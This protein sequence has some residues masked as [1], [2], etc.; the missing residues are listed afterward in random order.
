MKRLILSTVC[1]LFCATGLWALNSISGIYYYLNAGTQTASVAHSDSYSGSKTIPSTVTYGGITYSVTSIG[2]DAFS[3]CSRLT[4][5]TIPNSVTSIGSSAFENCT[6]LTSVTIPNSVTSIGSSAF[7]GCG[8]T[9]Y[10]AHI[11]AHLPENDFGTYSIPEGIETIVSGA[12]SN[13]TGLTSVTIPNSVTSIGSSAFEN[14]SGLKEVINKSDLNITQGSTAN[15]Y[16]AYYA[17]YV[18]NGGKTVIGDFIFSDRD[19]TLV[20]YTGNG[21]NI[22]LPENFNGGSYTIGASAFSGNT[23]LTSITIPNSVTSIGSSAFENC[24]GLTSIDV[25]EGNANYTSIDGVLY[26]KEK[27]TLIKCPQT[28][29]SIEIQ[30]SV[31]SIGSSA[32]YNCSG[33]TS[34][35]IPS[36]VT[37]IGSSAFY[38]CSGLTSVEIPS[39]VTGIEN[40]AFYNV[41][42]IVYTGSA[43]GSPWGAIAIN[44]FVDGEFVF[45]D[46]TKTRLTAYIGNGGDV[47]IPSS[48][49]TIGNSAFYNCSRLTSIEIPNSVTSI[50]EYAFYDCSELTSVTLPNSVTSIGSKAFYN[51]SGLKEV[52][53]KS[54]L[55]ITQGSTANGYVAYYAD[56]VCN[57]GKTVIGDFIFS[58]RDKTLVKY[59]GNGGNITLPENFNGGSYTIGAS[60]FSGNTTLTSI[61]IPNSV[62]SIGNYVFKNCSGL[63]SVTIPNSVTSI[64]GNAFERCIRLT[65]ITIPNSVTSIGNYAFKNCSGL[66]SVTIPN[67]VTSIG[68]SAFENC[69]GLTIIAIPSSVTSIGSSAFKGCARLK[70]VINKS[71]LNITKGSTANGYVAYYADIV[72]NEGTVIGD[73]I[74]SD[75]DKTLVEYIGNGGDIT[76]PENF[77]GENYTIG[78]SAFSGNTTLTSVVISNSVTGI[79][80]GAF[81]GCSRLTS[82][83]VPCE[84]YD[85]F[86]GMLTEYA[87]IIYEN[88]TFEVAVNA[89]NEDYGTVTG[90]GVFKM[91]QTIQLTATANEGYRFKG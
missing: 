20:K 15:G 16:V 48:V 10:N 47:T 84:K 26:D 62:T 13:C 1:M 51:C 23:T 60:A 12:F 2:E 8:I 14:C 25:A 75:Q 67:S 57:G 11:F 27:K 7:S 69:T 40:S 83:I 53:N 29:T 22:T 55:N 39:G 19:K 61:A 37:D 28:K 9:V 68:S 38:N 52:I 85:Y 77:N 21:G 66:T 76:L 90:S 72:S 81:S 41:R 30:N 33:L 73:F 42:H 49:T 86:V 74:F 24:S 46:N 88:C 91:G 31:T 34:V 35:E 78:A 43:M 59:T 89:N 6:G 56:Y 79:V 58:D 80:D 18:C 71:A 36:G 32:F 70:R 45:S 65:S 5:I 50:E 4:S 87:A 44:G 63:T 3:G 64:G 82:I 54:D 17:D